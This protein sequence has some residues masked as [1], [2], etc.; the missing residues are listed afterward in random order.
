MKIN[1]TFMAGKIFP[2]DIESHTTCSDVCGVIEGVFSVKNPGD[3][4]IFETFGE[5]GMFSSIFS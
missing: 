5:L 4:T 1:V 2:V 3:F